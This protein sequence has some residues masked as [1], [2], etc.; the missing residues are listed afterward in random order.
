MISEKHNFIFILPP[1]NSSTSIISA[2]KDY[3]DIDLYIPQQNLN[4]FD[5]HEDPKFYIPDN[6][7]LLRKH[8]NLRTYKAEYIN[9]SAIYCSI[10]NPFDRLV[11]F[12]KWWTKSFEKKYSLKEFLKKRKFS[13][14]LRFVYSDLVSLDDI[15]F[16]RQE[17]IQHD[18]DLACDKIGIPRQKLPHKNKTD[19]KHYT[20]YY[21]DETREIVAEKYAQDI[22]Y[23][24]YKFGE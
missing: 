8:A 22:E 14:Q 19:H 16:V 15:F 5:F 10:R 24:G 1:K 9:K 13:S 11:S 7:E 6:K 20:E 17:N 18:L 12:Y 4:T 21:D 2:L 23:F 3:V